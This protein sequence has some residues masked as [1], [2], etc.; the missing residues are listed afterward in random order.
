MVFL[1][2]KTKRKCQDGVKESSLVVWDYW[3]SWKIKN[4]KQKTKNKQKTKQ[5]SRGVIFSQWQEGCPS[6]WAVPPPHAVLEAPS[7]SPAAG[8]HLA[9]NPK[10][11]SALSVMDESIK[12][13]IQMHSVAEMHPA[14]HAHVCSEFQTEVGQGNTCC[15]AAVQV[16]SELHDLGK[17]WVILF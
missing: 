12:H 16:C 4:K 2:Q 14:N 6:S 3:C 10:L 15:Y 7:S 11:V 8:L 13:N 1:S 17:F 5:N 9:L